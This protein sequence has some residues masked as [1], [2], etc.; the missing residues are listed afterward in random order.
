V[1]EISTRHESLM[2]SA[3]AFI[4]DITYSWLRGCVIG[5]YRVIGASAIAAM[6]LIRTTFCGDALLFNRGT[7]CAL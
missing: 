5:A 6:F 3:S 7:V 1:A 4:A 2:K